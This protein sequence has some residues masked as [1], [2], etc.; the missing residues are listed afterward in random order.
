MHLSQA[1]VLM[2][3]IADLL[4]QKG[5]GGMLA[6]CQGGLKL[7]LTTPSSSPGEGGNAGAQTWVVVGKIPEEEGSGV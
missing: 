5:L 2:D 6:W 3:C 7:K 4:A 1:Q